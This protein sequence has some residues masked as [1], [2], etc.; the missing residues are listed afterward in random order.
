[1][2]LHDDCRFTGRSPLAE[3]LQALKVKLRIMQ[4]CAKVFSRNSVPNVVINHNLFRVLARMKFS[5]S[6]IARS[7]LASKR[8]KM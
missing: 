8:V 5:N 4:F 3:M 2:E 6:K 1:M 7:Q